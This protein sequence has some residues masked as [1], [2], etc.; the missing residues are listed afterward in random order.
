MP[1][2]K[3]VALY[4]NAVDIYNPRNRFRSKIP[5][6]FGGRHLGETS[7]HQASANHLDH[8]TTAVPTEEERSQEEWWQPG[9]IIP[10][11]RQKQNSR[12]LG[13]GG[14][15]EKVGSTDRKAAELVAN[16]AWAAL[17]DSLKFQLKQHV[18]AGLLTGARGNEQISPILKLLYL[19][20][21]LWEANSR[22][23]F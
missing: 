6:R 18:S 7:V 11:S 10:K 4:R 9:L 17:G 23:C 16:V 12:K 20:P 2:D 15:R 22:N 13:G 8:A 5:L 1:P 14:G 21:V 19:L 3:W